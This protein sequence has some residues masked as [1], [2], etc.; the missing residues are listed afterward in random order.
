MI[1]L[2][3]ERD[4]AASCT[5]LFN[6]AVKT[7]SSSYSSVGENFHLYP[8]RQFFFNQLFEAICAIALGGLFRNDVRETNQNRLR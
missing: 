5:S 7:S 2:N 3:L 8:A 4:G 1:A 6:R